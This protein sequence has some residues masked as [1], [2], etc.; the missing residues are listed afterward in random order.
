[1]PYCNRCGTGY[2]LGEG[3]CPK[4]GAELPKVRDDEVGDRKAEFGLHPPSLRRVLA[5]LIDMAVAYGLFAWVLLLLS[6]RFPMARSFVQI[7][8][9]AFVLLIPNPYLILKDALHGQSIGKLITGLVAYNEEERRAGG[10]MDSVRRNWYLGVPLIG[11]TLLAAVI[12]AQ[13]LSGR[14]RRI[15]DSTAHTRVITDLD[16]QRLR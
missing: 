15:G 3:A 1:M 16:Y 10:V 2:R 11:P 9:A 12:G 6:R 4:C 8:G 5:G 13:V 14:P 7:L